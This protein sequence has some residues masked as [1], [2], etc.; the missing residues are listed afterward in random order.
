[1]QLIGRYDIEMNVFF[2]G[3]WQDT[4]FIIIFKEFV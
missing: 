2:Y 1:M 4:K 3:Y